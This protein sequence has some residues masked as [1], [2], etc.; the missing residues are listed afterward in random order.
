MKVR[1]FAVAYF[2]LER[3]L[4]LS[5]SRLQSKVGKYDFFT[6]NISLKEDNL[7]NAYYANEVSQLSK[8]V[9]CRLLSFEKT[10]RLSATTAFE[11][12]VRSHEHYL[13]GQHAL[14]LLLPGYLDENQV[15]SLHP[16]AA[17]TSVYNGRCYQQ[18]QMYKGADQKLRPTDYAQ[19]VFKL[20][21]V[22]TFFSDL[23]RLL[24]KN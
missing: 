2:V 9:H 1:L 23:Q 22:L 13:Q 18:L 5:L 19:P 15:V 11:K 17:A 14:V 24:A 7:L 10:A 6:R 3:D 8:P 4:T 12:K 20:P 21:E 16:D